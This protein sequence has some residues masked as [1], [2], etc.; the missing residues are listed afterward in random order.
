VFR[1]RGEV[2]GRTKGGTVIELLKQLTA[3]DWKLIFHKHRKWSESI[4]RVSGN[5][6]WDDD[7]LNVIG[8]RCN[9]VLRYYVRGK[10]D[11]ND[12]LVMVLGESVTIFPCTTK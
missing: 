1:G 3:S 4:N 9:D 7:G 11:W 10:E 5:P 6:Q 8:I 2:G 12:C